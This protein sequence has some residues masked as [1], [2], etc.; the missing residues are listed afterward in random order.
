MVNYLAGPSTGETRRERGSPTAIDSRAEEEQ[1][2][3]HMEARTQGRKQ[4]PQP[5]PP[6]TVELAGAGDDVHG[7]AAASAEGEAAA[8]AL[9]AAEQEGGGATHSTSGV[10]DMAGVSFNEAVGL[11]SKDEAQVWSLVQCGAAGVCMLASCGDQLS[12]ICR[13]LL[14]F[15][16]LRVSSAEGMVERTIVPPAATWPWMRS[17]EAVSMPVESCC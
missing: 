9:G 15:G 13:P 7:A 10:Q 17:L 12:A 2:G 3:T 4:R 8:A 11:S 14:P 1:Q 16:N 5:Q 6:S